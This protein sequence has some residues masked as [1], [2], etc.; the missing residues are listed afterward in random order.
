MLW[1]KKG[2][3]MFIRTWTLRQRYCY[4]Q[5]YFIQVFSMTLPYRLLPLLTFSL[6]YYSSVSASLLGHVLYSTDLMSA[7]YFSH[8]YL[9]V[10]RYCHKLHLAISPSIIRQFSWSQWLW[11]ALEKTFWSIP[12]MSWGNQYWPSYWANQ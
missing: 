4:D 10:H 3:K 12:V 1:K 6:L 7:M 2:Y 11:K 9:M 5:P 8:F